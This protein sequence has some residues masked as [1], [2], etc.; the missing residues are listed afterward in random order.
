[1]SPPFS[2]RWLH[3]Q[4]VP[5]GFLRLYILTLLSRGPETGYSIMQKI[6]DR[7]DGAW[8]PGPGT[9]YPLLKGLLAEGLARS[10]GSEG[11]TGSKT[12]SLTQKGRRE[13]EETRRGIASMGRKEPV[14]GRLFSDLLPATIF[15]PWVIS[16]YRDGTGTLRQKMKEIPQPERN[17][18]LKE[19]RFILQSQVE[20]I[21]SQLEV[22]TR[23][24]RAPKRAKPTTKL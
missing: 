19:L 14:M 10:T 22:G 15:V 11:R 6:E 13:L 1:M 12:Y 17:A 24:E 7:T 18:I 4:T 9:M 20:W 3:P 2:K 5:R 16:R 21:D 23:P 8:R